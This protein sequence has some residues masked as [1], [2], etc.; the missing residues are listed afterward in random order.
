MKIKAIIFDM[1]GTIIDTT[2][3]WSQANNS[4]IRSKK[5]DICNIVLKEILDKVH[6]LALPYTCQVIKDT[7]KIN[8]SIENLIDQKVS[9]V[10]SLYNNGIKFIDGFEKFYSHVKANNLITAIATN[11]DLYTLQSAKNS[12]N[13]EMFFGHNIYDI[14]YVNNVCKPNPDIYLYAINKINVSFNQ[15][16]AIE[17]SA[18]GIRA[19]KAAGIF[20]IG[21]NTAKDREKLNEADY[22]VDNY[23]QIDLEKISKIYF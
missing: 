16:I 20:C 19:A 13:L 14:S 15:C 4:L 1:D 22:V 3:I 7:L 21:I 8:D 9:I 23:E 12:L 17:D 11:A 18:N 6:G 10:T 2:D 5:P